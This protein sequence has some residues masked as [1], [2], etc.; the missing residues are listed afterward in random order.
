MTKPTNDFELLRQLA[1]LRPRNFRVQIVN[2]AG[3][4][5]H[6]AKVATKEEA[7]RYILEHRQ[8][9]DTAVTHHILN[10]CENN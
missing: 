5:T 7:R 4:I 10:S 2:P 3:E 6:E 8:E 9:K 1:V